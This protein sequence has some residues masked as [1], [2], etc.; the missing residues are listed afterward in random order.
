[1]ALALTATCL[2]AQWNVDGNR[3]VDLRA[4]RRAV[5]SGLHGHLY[6]FGNQE[7]RFL[8]P[9]FA[10]WVLRPLAWV[11]ETTATHAWLVV[12]VLAG[13]AAL[14]A[15]VAATGIAGVS[16]SGPRAAGMC[17]AHVFGSARSKIWPA[18]TNSLQCPWRMAASQEA[19]CAR[20]LAG[21]GPA[22]GSARGPVSGPRQRG[23]PAAP[24]L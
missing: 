18:G 24:L 7:F 1:M 4:Y 17:A 22:D 23:R 6:D 12:S 13:L 15:L 8:Y 19:A 20:S 10:A 11:S 21:G 2:V 14:T 16:E 5:V 3:R 9:P